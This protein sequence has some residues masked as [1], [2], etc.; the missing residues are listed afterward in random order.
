[1][2]VVQGRIFEIIGAQYHILQT[3]KDKTLSALLI[4]NLLCDQHKNLL[5]VDKYC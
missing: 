5:L 3:R 1:M 4:T 2:W